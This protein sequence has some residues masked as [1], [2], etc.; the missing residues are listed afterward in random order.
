M[1]FWFSDYQIVFELPF[2][3][4]VRK[5]QQTPAPWKYDL[6]NKWMT[7]YKKYPK[8]VVA[9]KDMQKLKAKWKKQAEFQIEKPPGPSKAKIDMKVRNQR[10]WSLSYH[11]LTDGLILWRMSCW[12]MIRFKKRLTLMISSIRPR[13]RV[14]Q[15]QGQPRTS[16]TRP[17]LKSS[18]LKLLSSFP[19]SRETRRKKRTFLR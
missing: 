11:L 19:C 12:V 10:V 4:L 5:S 9:P 14:T 1:M 2:W 8:V 18:T 6:K 3:F 13:R 16:K 15:L 17:C 7:G